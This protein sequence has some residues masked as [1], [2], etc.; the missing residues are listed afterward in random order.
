MSKKYNLTAI[1]NN[2]TSKEME[3]NSHLGNKE[4]TLTKGKD[5]KGNGDMQEDI[6]A[7]VCLCQ[8]TPE[9]MRP[10]NLSYKPTHIP[11]SLPLTPCLTQIYINAGHLF[12]T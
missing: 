5:K 10:P 6:Q 12:Y 7:V 2:R 11:P 3:L 8:K 4:I 9:T 1:P